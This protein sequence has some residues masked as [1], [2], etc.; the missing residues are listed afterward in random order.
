MCRPLLQLLLLGFGPP[1]GQQ[2]MG[3]GRCS[4]RRLG[5]TSHMQLHSWGRH[6]HT[7]LCKT[8]LL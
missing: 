1:G 2:G 3:G 4:V 8:G 5:V 7:V 6:A